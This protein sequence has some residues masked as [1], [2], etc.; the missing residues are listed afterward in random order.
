MS[1]ICYVDPWCKHGLA[2]G[3]SD[4]IDEAIRNNNIPFA[5]S[6]RLCKICFDL[7]DTSHVMPTYEKIC[8]KCSKQKI[9]V[10]KRKRDK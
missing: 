6:S 3:V 7:L 9:T 4:M 1:R 8:D 5:Q 2:P 10:L